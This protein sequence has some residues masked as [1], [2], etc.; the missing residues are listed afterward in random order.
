MP[1]LS[2]MRWSI[3]I[4]VALLL[5]AGV[6]F[7]WSGSHPS[8]VAG[9]PS[10]I[11]SLVTGGA[12]GDEYAGERRELQFLEAAL[13]RLAA[14]VEQQANGLALDSLRT[15]QKAVL[16][17]MRQVAS[18]MPA[19]SL[20]PDIRRLLEPTAAPPP[21]PGLAP[22]AARSVEEAAPMRPA[23]ELRSGL[24]P[25]APVV[26]FSFLPPAAP[27]L[28]PIFIG[29]PPPSRTKPAPPTAAPSN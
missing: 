21:V 22:L 4:V 8:R 3:G 14:E 17:R 15:E 29:R 26:D 20:P 13:H 7:S 10:A 1:K 28:L 16:Q 18:R 25:P 2:A 19:D 11:F 5:I 27:A 6:S 23:V 12:A 24:L 9:R